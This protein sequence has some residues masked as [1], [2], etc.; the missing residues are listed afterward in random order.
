[1]PVPDANINVDMVVKKLRD[2]NPNKSAGPDGI[3]GRVNKETADITPLASLHE[4]TVRSMWKEASSNPKGDKNDPGNYR[5]ISI[6]SIQ[7]KIMKSLIRYAINVYMHDSGQ[8]ALEQHGFL[9][10]RSCNTNLIET[11]DVPAIWTR[12]YRWISFI[13][14]LV[15]A[16]DTV[17]HRRLI[18]KLKALGVCKRIIVWIEDFLRT[19]AGKG[20]GNIFF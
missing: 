18:H 15:K 13:L 6:T 14:T 4:G 12:T 3:H 8:L 10:G 16:F 1:M 20:H 5:P 19:V 2:I 17:P 9:P 7:C 11:I